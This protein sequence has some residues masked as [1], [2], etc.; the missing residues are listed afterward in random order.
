MLLRETAKRT[1]R[2]LLKENS[3]V[4]IWRKKHT[5][6][7][8]QDRTLCPAVASHSCSI[9]NKTGILL[10]SAAFVEVFFYLIHAI[11]YYLRLHSV[12][13]AAFLSLS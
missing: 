2:F 13:P 7:I 10:T 9:V 11:F 1:F 3:T 12:Y 8:I 5:R 4:R 6:R